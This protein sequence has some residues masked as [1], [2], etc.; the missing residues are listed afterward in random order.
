[1]YNS[2][3]SSINRAPSASAWFLSLDSIVFVSLQFLEEKPSGY[4]VHSLSDFSNL[5]V[6]NAEYLS[7]VGSGVVH[8]GGGI[9]SLAYRRRRP[10]HIRQKDQARSALV[11]RLYDNGFSSRLYTGTL[12]EPFISLISL[13]L[14]MYAFVILM[15]LS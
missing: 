7:S 13:P 11:R 5:K 4:Q 9:H 14:I 15:V 3:H 12:K 6:R 10:P 8:R 2:I 1:M